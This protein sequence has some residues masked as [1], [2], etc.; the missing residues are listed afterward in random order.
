MICPSLP[1][2]NYN[3]VC[4]VPGS[5][6]WTVR[7]QVLTAN[8][9]LLAINKSWSSTWSPSR[10]E[11]M[12]IRSAAADFRF[13]SSSY[14]V[15]AV[16]DRMAPISGGGLRKSSRWAVVESRPVYIC[17]DSAPVVDISHGGFTIVLKLSFS[18]S[19]SLHSHLSLAQAQFLK[20][21]HSVFGSHW[22]W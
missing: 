2:S 1:V 7:S 22:R 8:L 19:L 14:H 18:Q 17:S 15:A 5:A 3:T 4:S 12:H 10:V 21:Y 20:F 6:C 13:R 16:S 11:S 9:D